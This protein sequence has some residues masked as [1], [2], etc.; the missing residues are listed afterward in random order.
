MAQDGISVLRRREETS[1]LPLSLSIMVGHSKKE[2]VCKPKDSS[3]YELKSAGNFILEVSRTMRNKCPL[4]KPL[5]LGYHLIAA[6]Q[7]NTPTEARGRGFREIP[8]AFGHCHMLSREQNAFHKLLLFFTVVTAIRYNFP[9][10]ENKET[11]PG[12][13]TDLGL[14]QGHTVGD[15]HSRKASAV[16]AI[17]KALGLSAASRLK[18]FRAEA[19]KVAVLGSRPFALNPGKAPNFTMNASVYL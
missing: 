13:S 1:E 2:T 10:F 16:L 8:V 18:D 14:V 17:P 5:G 7:A 12:K 11:D 9:W 4:F 19:R 3:Q 15:G 6:G